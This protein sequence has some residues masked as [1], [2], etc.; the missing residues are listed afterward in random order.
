MKVASLNK[1]LNNVVQTGDHEVN[2]QKAESECVR[3]TKALMKVTSPMMLIC[4]SP[5]AA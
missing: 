5:L 4:I 3:S 2:V 1:K